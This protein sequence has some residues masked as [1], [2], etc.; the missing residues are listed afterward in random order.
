MTK[1]L[2]I[3]FIMITVMLDAMGIGL[4]MPVMPDLIQEVGGGTLATAAVWGGVLTTSFAMMQFLFSP[5][6]GRLSD[7]FGRRPVLLV[8]LFVMSADYLV[9]ALAGSIWL[10]LAG[11]II[12]G[13]T[14]ATHSTA[15]AYMADISRPEDKAANFG[16]IGA[17]FGIGFVLGP[18][19]GGLLAEYG[20]RAPFYAAAVLAFANAMFGLTVLKETVTEKTRRAFDLKGANPF[21]ALRA[22][23]KLGGAVTPLLWVLLLYH[24]ANVV[25]PAVWAYFSTAKFG[26]SPGLIGVS[27]AVYGVSMA[28][29][30]GALIR[31]ASRLFG[32]MRTVQIGIGIEVIALILV[33]MVSNGWV[34][35]ALIPISA[36]GAIA[37]PAL[38]G[39]LSRIAPDDQQGELQGVLASIASI[40]MIIGPLIMTQVFSY[41]AADDAPWHQPGAPFLLAAVLMAI[42]GLVF[43]ASGRQVR[44]AA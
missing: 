30:Q 31:P 42:G 18:M 13:I 41:F 17:G 43:A 8:S 4:I 5:L 36:L 12:G 26:W 6:L 33:G 19:L 39:I 35:M 23:S 24:L 3:V 1:R 15:H 16:L 9:M 32:D 29:V 22:I 2:P 7:A 27:L 25:Y 28:V 20:T 44:A 11:R 10:L 34:I 40:S 38:Q 14:A 21:S 37:Q